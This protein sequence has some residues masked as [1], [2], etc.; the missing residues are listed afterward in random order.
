MNKLR[1]SILPAM[2]VMVL[3]AATMLA[4]ENR[5]NISGRVYN[6]LDANVVCTGTG[7]PGVGGIVIAGN[8]VE[9]NSMGVTTLDD[10]TYQ[11]TTVAFGT[12]TVRVDPG[13]NW[14]ATTN[15]ERQ[16]VVNE[17]N[18]DVTNVDFCITQSPLPTLPESGAPIVTNLVLVT[19]AGVG[20]VLAGLFVFWIGRKV[21]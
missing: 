10:G 21:N 3:G 9:G 17:E 4:Q 19:A 20:L 13:D 11:L 12:W 1:W 5:G 7:E 15:P 6:D 16:V 8:S 2:V 14:T 18:R